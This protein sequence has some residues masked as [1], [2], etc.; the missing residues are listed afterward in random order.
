MGH[1]INILFTPPALDVQYPFIARLVP[2]L[3][4]SV[5]K[6][7][8]LTYYRGVYDGF[9]AGVLV[10]LLFVPTIKNRFSEVASNAVSQL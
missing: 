1:I 8:E 5:I 10:T 9:V 4:V 7:L 2:A 6:A 3:K